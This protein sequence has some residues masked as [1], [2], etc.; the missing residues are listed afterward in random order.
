MYHRD[1]LSALNTLIYLYPYH[2]QINCLYWVCSSTM[3]TNQT[4]KNF[5]ICRSWFEL[6]QPIICGLTEYMFVCSWSM[7][8]RLSSFALDSLTLY[9]SYT[10][11]TTCST[12]DAIL[13]SYI[14]AYHTAFLSTN[15][16]CPVTL[17]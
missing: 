14:V 10:E 17:P 1:P 9:F 7:L 16:S 13:C 5:H 8:H 3:Y 6:Q 12:S 2:L 11:T 15:V 4:I